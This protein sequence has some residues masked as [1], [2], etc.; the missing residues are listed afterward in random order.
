VPLAPTHRTVSTHFVIVAAKRSVTLTTV[1]AGR[2]EFMTHHTDGDHVCSS[3]SFATAVAAQDRCNRQ[4]HARCRRGPCNWGYLGIELERHSSKQ[5]LPTPLQSSVWSRRW[6]RF[7]Y[8][9]KMLWHLWLPR[10]TAHHIGKSI[11]GVAI[12]QE[13]R[14]RSSVSLLPT[15]KHYMAAVAEYSSHSVL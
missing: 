4:R 6:C 5:A 13:T 2:H 1:T 3:G 11:A 15:F 9:S 12:A 14:F 10:W 7:L 8:Q